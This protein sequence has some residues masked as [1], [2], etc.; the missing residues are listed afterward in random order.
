MKKLLHKTLSAGLILMLFLLSA[1]AN[2]QT[3]CYAI[4]D[5]QQT[6]NSLNVDF[7]DLSTSP[8]IITSWHW[9]FGD[10]TSSTS[11]SPS[12]EYTQDGDYNVCLTIH[13][14]HGCSNNSCHNIVV[15]PIEN[16][17]CQALFE[18][19]QISNALILEFTDLSSSLYTI[20]SWSWDFGDGSSSSLQNPVHTYAHDGSYNVCLT[21]HDSHGCHHTYCNQIIVNP[22]EQL[23]CHASFD[24]VQIINTLSVD[25][26]DKSTSSYNINSWYWDFGD[27]EISTLQNPS[28]TYAHS[29][30]YY[31]CLTIHDDH[32]CSSTYCHHVTIDSVSQSDCHAL[33]GFSQIINT[34]TINFTDSSSSQ[35]SI[36]AWLWN[37][38]DGN[39]STLQNP[40]YTYAHPG[41]YFVCLTIM[42]N[43]GCH[44]TSCHHITVEQYVQNDCHAAFVFEQISNT[45]TI[46]F[47]D[48][49]SSQNLIISW[50]WDFGDGSSSDLQN[51]TH[52]YSHDGNYYVCLTISDSSSCHNTTCHHIMV[53]HFDNSCHASFTFHTDSLE[54]IFNFTNTSS[55]TNSQT[56]YLWDFGDGQTSTEENP[57]H[58]YTNTG[59]YLVCLFIQDTT[60]GCSS[61]VCQTIHYYHTVIHHHHHMLAPQISHRSNSPTEMEI[62]NDLNYLKCYPNPFS[63]NA[64]IQYELTEPA[65]VKL[66]IYDLIGN[67]L[68]QMPKEKE[69]IG[70]HHRTINAN[71]FTSS[72]YLIK[73][74]VGEELF[75]KKVSVIK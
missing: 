44:N 5:Y 22:I 39:T 35:N 58:T 19:N 2:S 21:I 23:D 72:L 10:G 36:I 47:T 29:G 49:S 54:N 55:G 4:F 56:T 46:N 31:V 20:T 50:L 67:C 53:N 73:M 24:F 64:S 32:G 25:F 17:D 69:S 26:T 33:F 41:T 34:L 3:G 8:N 6:S 40:S 48:S 18:S 27:G 7:T 9:D 66:E 12:H 28:H 1:V 15:N 74:T 65:E 11:Q 71:N 16:N 45:L 42:D 75:L 51:P 57:T 70:I 60:N 63:S 59:T 13:D 43:T 68:I 61:H 52:T 62:L 14:V 38:G 37:F 30:T